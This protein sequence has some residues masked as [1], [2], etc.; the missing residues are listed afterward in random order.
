MNDI[1]YSR[2]MGGLK[3]AGVE[4]DRK[5]LSNMAILDAESFAKLVQLAKAANA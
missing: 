3:K 5:V 4:L 1:S 2:F